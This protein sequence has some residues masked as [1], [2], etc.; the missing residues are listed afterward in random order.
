M[1]EAFPSRRHCQF[2]LTQGQRQGTNGPRPSRNRSLRL[3]SP[4]RSELAQRGVRAGQEL[5]ANTWQGGSRALQNVPRTRKWR[6]SSSHQDAPGGLAASQAFAVTLPWP[7]KAGPVQ[8]MWDLPWGNPWVASHDGRVTQW[9]DQPGLEGIQGSPKKSLPVLP[10]RD[11]S[12][13]KH[14]PAQPFWEKTRP[15][16]P[17]C[18]GHWQGLLCLS[19]GQSLQ[20]ERQSTPVSEVRGKLLQCGWKIPSGLP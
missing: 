13:I 11:I 5:V 4:S 16:R 12:H 7:D 18:S 10:G 17:K 14:L 6:L 15:W 9:A 1:A 19:Q 3:I 8:T 20:V 2:L